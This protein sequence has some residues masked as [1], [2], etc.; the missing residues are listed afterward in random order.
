MFYENE[1][2]QL[3]SCRFF[4]LHGNKYKDTI[5][6]LENFTKSIAADLARLLISKGRIFLFFFKGENLVAQPG[7][8]LVF[9]PILYLGA[10]QRVVFTT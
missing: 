3:G 4:F 1:S 5:V 8:T 2:T 7:Y 9:L 6:V 10:A